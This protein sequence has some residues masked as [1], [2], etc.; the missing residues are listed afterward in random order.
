MGGLCGGRNFLPQ[1]LLLGLEGSGKSVFLEADTISTTSAPTSTLGYKLGL[2]KV[3]QFTLQVWDVGGKEPLIPLWPAFY[4]NILYSAVIFLID[5]EDPSTFAR[6][7]R[8]LLL[9]TNEEELREAIF[10][11]ILNSKSNKELSGIE[12]YKEE[13]QLNSIHP[14]VKYACFNVDVKGKT[15]DYKSAMDFLEKQLK[16]KLIKKGKAQE[17][18]EEQKADPEVN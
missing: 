2:M 13:L 10:L 1:G 7:R 6:A 18:E 15:R 14:A 8:E 11:I 3:G 4:R 9:L 12:Y 16:I 17:E 5:I